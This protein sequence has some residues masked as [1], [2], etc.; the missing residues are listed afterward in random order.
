[1]EAPV[2]E[3]PLQ[4]TMV[5]AGVDIVLKCI[6]A[7]T[8]NPEGKSVLPVNKKMG[9]LS[10]QTAPFFPFAIVT[11][12]KDNA[13]ITALTNYTVKVEG[14]RH[15]LLIKSTRASD[16]GKYCV[17]A[18]NQVGRASSS[19]ILT[20]KSGEFACPSPF[21]LPDTRND[22]AQFKLKTAGANFQSSP[23]LKVMF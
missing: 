16:G 6:I 23:K 22:I 11:W 4:D 15:S 21:I 19:A 3:F 1:M 9:A 7:G 20:V 13:E 8:P 10:T 12:T 17:T 14:E 18:V 5:S 2:F